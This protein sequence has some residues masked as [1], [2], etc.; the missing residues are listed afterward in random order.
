M[1]SISTGTQFQKMQIMSQF[2]PHHLT[3]NSP[4]PILTAN[5]T[6]SIM[7]GGVL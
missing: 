6:L 7:V 5:A 3:L 1:N 2:H 4:W